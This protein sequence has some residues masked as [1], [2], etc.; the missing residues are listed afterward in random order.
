MTELCREFNKS[1]KVQLFDTSIVQDSF[2]YKAY[3]ILRNICRSLAHPPQKKHSGIKIFK[4]YQNHGHS[5]NNVS[6][7]VFVTH[8]EIEK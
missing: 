5:K 4:K 3:N 1:E 8:I 6:V 7:E 2:P